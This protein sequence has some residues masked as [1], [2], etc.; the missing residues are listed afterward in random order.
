MALLGEGEIF[1]GM[2]LTSSSVRTKTVN[3]DS[4]PTGHSGTKGWE[5]RN[6]KQR[7]L[8]ETRPVDTSIG[9]DNTTQFPEATSIIA[10]KGTLKGPPLGSLPSTSKPA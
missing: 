3:L 1:W 10:R 7:R 8:C 4:G 9:V 5:V 6:R 2:H